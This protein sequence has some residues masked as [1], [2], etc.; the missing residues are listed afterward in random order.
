[1]SFYNEN[2]HPANT[3]VELSKH[4]II[5]SN[6]SKQDTLKMLFPWHIECTNP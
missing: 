1:M 3:N 4:Q 6:I 2:Q 5:E